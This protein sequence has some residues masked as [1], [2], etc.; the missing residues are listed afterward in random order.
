MPMILTAELKRALAELPEEVF[1]TRSAAHLRREHPELIAGLDDATLEA[2]VR[3]SFARARACGITWR[4][5]LLCFAGLSLLI[6]PR[7]DEHPP[8]RRILH[9][10]NTDPEDRLDHAVRV[11][12]ESDWEAAKASPAL[13]DWGDAVESSTSPDPPAR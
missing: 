9:D 4:R 5:N 12:T 11:T 2:R 3:A 6:A 13:A 8:I 1:V 7:F 10:A